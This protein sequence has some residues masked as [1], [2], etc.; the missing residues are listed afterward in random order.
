M[1][2]TA[3]EKIARDTLIVLGVDPNK[4]SRGSVRIEPFGSAFIVRWEGMAILDPEALRILLGGEAVE[5]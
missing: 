1:S 5:A 4:V 2:L 3:A